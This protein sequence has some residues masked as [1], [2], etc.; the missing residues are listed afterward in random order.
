[1]VDR[2]LVLVCLWKAPQA[3]HKLSLTLWKIPTGTKLRRS[4]SK[5]CRKAATV[6]LAAFTRSAC[7]FLSFFRRSCACRPAGNKHIQPLEIDLQN[8]FRL[9]FAVPQVAEPCKFLSK[10][11]CRG[12]GSGLL[13]ASSGNTNLQLPAGYFLFCQLCRLLC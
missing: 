11:S 10:I 5:G 12:Q 2:M 6:R 7:S 4:N 1:M 3:V 9:P 8:P 13:L